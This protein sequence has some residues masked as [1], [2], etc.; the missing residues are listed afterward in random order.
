MTLVVRDE[1]DVI[2]AQIRYH[3]D[4][5]VD[6]VLATDHDSQDGTAE[7]LEQ[8]AGKGVLQLIREAGPMR[9]S[10]WRTRMARLAAVEHGADWIVNADADEFWWPCGGTLRD[11]LAAVPQEFGV[12]S[13][14]T[15]HFPP[16]PGDGFF[17]ERMTV[18]V[19]GPAAIN[20]PTSPWRPHTKAAHRAD[21]DIV[22]LFGSHSVSSRS[23]VRLRGWFPADVLHFP[24]RSLEQYQRK[25]VRRAHGDKPLGQ[26]VK[27]YQQHEQ[28]RS[29]EGYA[30]VCVDDDAVERGVGA[31]SLAV[32]VR[33]RDA[34]R[35]Q[36][37][38]G[39]QTTPGVV[40]STADQAA[41][42]ADAGVVR[43]ANLVRLQRR[44]DELAARVP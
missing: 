29:S 30:A 44:L 10:F 1:A 24:V 42:A 14:L 38:S 35:E 25:T 11:V 8:Y 43:E 16:R 5:G 28:G 13:G 21:P 4:A 2:D 31:G 9:E 7:I 32:D 27:G 41:R 40:R 12:V 15:R 6:F 39:G 37:A 18:R 22:V 17:A 34:L 23:L 36:R 3:L 33:L 26:Y 19:A 20:D